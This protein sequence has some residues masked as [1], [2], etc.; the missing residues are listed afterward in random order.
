MQGAWGIFFCCSSSTSAATLNTPP[1]C[2]NWHSRHT[3]VIKMVMVVTSH[4]VSILKEKVLLVGVETL[5][6]A[7]EMATLPSILLFIVIIIER[8]RLFAVAIG[9]ICLN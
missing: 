2:P 3:E 1:H 9:S 4:P 7:L 8:E 5:L 6:Q